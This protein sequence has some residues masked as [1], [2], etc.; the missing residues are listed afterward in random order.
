MSFDVLIHLDPSK[1]YLQVR[2]RYDIDLLAKVKAIPGRLFKPKLG[3]AWLIPFMKERVETIHELFAPSRVYIDVAVLEHL[4]QQDR[5][6]AEVLKVRSEGF[7]PDL[8]K[9]DLPVGFRFN[10][11]PFMH[12]RL[13]LH[14]CLKHPLFGLFMEMGTGKTK[15]VIDLVRLVKVNGSLK[16]PCLVICPVS[17][18]DV[19][20][21]EALKHQPDLKVQ[22][23]SGPMGS[24]V[25]LLDESL[26]IGSD[27]I[28]VN[29]EATWRMEAELMKVGWGLMILDEST[30][31]KHRASKQS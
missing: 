17:V 31:I 30:R 8:L 15:V 3:N 18:M 1:A 6:A 27:I 4:D 16:G 19:W 22:I 28:V 10:I 11:E 25:K 23:L 26:L 9:N 7:Q 20:R 24:R 2:F 5:D 12:Q 13:A 14:L 29:Y 21:S